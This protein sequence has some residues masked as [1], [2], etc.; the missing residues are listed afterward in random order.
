M[1]SAPTSKQEKHVATFEVPYE[2]GTL[3]VLGYSGGKQVADLEIQTVDAPAAVRLTPDRE[4][5]AAQPGDLVYKDG[6]VDPTAEHLIHFSV[7][8]AGRIAAVGNGNPKST[9]MYR[10]NRRRAFRGRCLVVLKSNGEPG[11]VVLRARADGL[12]GQAL[13]VHAT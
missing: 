7:H 12:E 3:K 9:E 2:R 11:E 5:C 8:G 4:T 1:G 13:T 6:L 10:G